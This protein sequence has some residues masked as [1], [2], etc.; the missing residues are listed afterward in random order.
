MVPYRPPDAFTTRT[1][2]TRPPGRAA[3]R[4]SPARDTADDEEVQDAGERI[5]FAPTPPLDR[6]SRSRSWPRCSTPTRHR[7]GL[8]DIVDRLPGLRRHPP[9][10]RAASVKV[11]AGPGR[12]RCRGGVRRM[13]HSAEFIGSSPPLL[14]YALLLFCECRG[15]SRTW[16]EAA[17]AKAAEFYSG[18]WG[19]RLRVHSG[20][21]RCSR[22]PARPQ[23]SISPT[24]PHCTRLLR[25]GPD[26][27]IA[28][29]KVVFGTSG[30]DPASTVPS[31]KHISRRS[32]GHRGSTGGP[33]HRLFIGGD[34]HALQSSRPRPPPLECSRRRGC[35]RSTNLTTSCHPRATAIIS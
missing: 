29:Q 26:V 13:R 12:S 1:S 9:P 18:H 35:A 25:P 20:A 11:P 33:G 24:S 6:S 16:G 8:A 23:T 2:P 27:S 28:E 5:L 30:A 14:H 15:A 31:T 19:N 22:R 32:A 3:A 34:T 4:S 21:W 10:G 7:R 17:H